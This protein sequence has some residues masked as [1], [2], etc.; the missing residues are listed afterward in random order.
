MYIFAENGTEK[1]DDQLVAA[2]DETCRKIH[3]YYRQSL[4]FS[5]L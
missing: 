3:Q 2:E 5:Y 1:Q 4:S